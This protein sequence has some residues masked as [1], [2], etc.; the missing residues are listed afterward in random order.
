MVNTAA[1]APPAVLNTARLRL[2][3]MG[4]EH[5]DGMME[6]L[7]DR[8]FQRLTGTH[9]H[10]TRLQVARFL[11]QITAA[12][13][14]ADWAILRASDDLYL[15]EVVLNQLDAHN[16]S[17]NF[18]IALN[19][20]AQVGQG[21]GTEA[22]CAVVAYGFGL[23]G[24]RRISLGVYAFNPRAR[25]V[26]EKCGFVH[27]GTERSAL[28]WQGEWVDQHRMAILSTDPRPQATAPSTAEAR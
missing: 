22:T 2:V 26:Y 21:Y 4:P 16:C 27:E 9:E 28:Y 13:D 15:G 23:V 20:P 18:R 10:F 17:M 5:L 1:L 8:E 19:S 11:E 12:T 14:R 6:G 7:Q 24:L 3:P 25:R